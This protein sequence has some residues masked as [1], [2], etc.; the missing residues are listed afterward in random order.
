MAKKPDFTW[1]RTRKKLG[2]MLID[3]G[4]LTEEKL[5]KYVAAQQRSGLKLG[6]FLIREGVVSESMIVELISQQAGIKKYNPMEFPVSPE[7][8]AKLTEATARKYHAIPLKQ[9]MQLLYVAMPDPLDIRSL[10]AIEVECNMEVEPVICSE[11]EFSH[12]FSLV[13]ETRV[14]AGPLAGSGFDLVDEMDFAEDE[15]ES[16]DLGTT[17]LSSLQHMAE[18]APVVRLVNTLLSQAIR[19]GA[20]DIHISPEKRYIQIRFRI[21]GSLHEMPAPPKQMF[22]SIVSRLKI[23]ANL[24]ISISRIP[25]DGRFSVKIENKDINIRVST[26]PTIYGENVVLRLLDTSSGVYTL[27]QL[28]MAADDQQKLKRNIAKPYG[29][30]LATGPTGSGKSTSLFAMM[31]RINTPD[32]NII[33]LE[34]PVE[35]RMEGI[36]QAQLNR[37]AGM[38][39]AGGLRSI[40]RQDPDVIMVGE[41]RDGETAAVA[42]QAALTGHM[43]F[44]T[45]H[46]NDA[47][48]AITRFIDMGVEPFLVA[49]V[50]L[51]S[52]AQRLVRKVCEYCAEDDHPSAKALS[53]MG[54]ENEPDAVFKQGKGCP[55]CL[56][57]GYRGRTGIYEILEID[58]EIQGMILNRKS[59]RQITQVALEAGKLR[60]LK[61]DAARKAALGITTLDEAISGVMG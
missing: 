19:Q 44:S 61:Q 46:T 60:T 3:A 27:D 38:T 13:Y 12:L 10:D 29:M 15:E 1:K 20:S 54:L 25:Q 47:A 45:V 14:D 22:L 7:H 39:F 51:V 24:D 16:P 26:I 58:D 34:D 23:L 17:E 6:Q 36:R 43:V 21:D 53:F 32:I 49:S 37:K 31:N 4:H 11:Q 5:S 59:G 30:I 56:N 33:T 55:Q 35:Y 28:G 2:E 41:I 8:A 50:M 9:D 48:G 42:T 57:T 18:E 52:I 40:L